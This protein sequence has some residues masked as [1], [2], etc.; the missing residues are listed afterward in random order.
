[1]LQRSLYSARVTSPRLLPNPKSAPPHL[2]RLVISACFPT[3]AFATAGLTTPK[4]ET[5]LDARIGLSRAAEFSA[6]VMMLCEERSRQNNFSS[7]IP[8][9]ELFCTEFAKFLPTRILADAGTV[10]DGEGFSAGDCDCVIFDFHLAPFVKLPS[11]VGSG[12][13]CFPVEVTFGSIEVKSPLTLGPRRAN[14]SSGGLRFKDGS[15][16]EACS[17]LFMYKELYRQE[18]TVQRFCAEPERGGVDWAGCSLMLAAC[19]FAGV[20][21]WTPAFKCVRPRPHM[22]GQMSLTRRNSPR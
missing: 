10:I 20:T 8:L 1:M 19:H 15:L 9:Q 11:V 17:K 3:R 22:C 14:P 18:F 7:G 6:N 13:K 5:E 4:R 21:G 12:H 2:W 16:H